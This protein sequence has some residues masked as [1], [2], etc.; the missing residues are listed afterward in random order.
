MARSIEESNVDK[1][2]DSRHVG[3][4]FTISFGPW[5]LISGDD[6]PKVAKSR[7]DQGLPLG[8]GPTSSH[9]DRYTLPYMCL[10]T[11]N[12]RS[13]AEQYSTVQYMQNSKRKGYE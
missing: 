8:S 4:S 2:R 13:P 5:S 9:A 6:G 10:T 11:R 12:F 3:A 7:N 1:R